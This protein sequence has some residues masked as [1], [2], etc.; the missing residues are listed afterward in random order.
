M[1]LDGAPT[2]RSGSAMTARIQVELSEDE[3]HAWLRVSPGAPVG[4]E[5]LRE[6]LAAAGVGHGIDADAVAELVRR[7]ADPEYS[8]ARIEIATGRAMQRASSGTCELAVPLGLQSGHRN[9]DGSFDYR[10]RG[11]LTV[12]ESGQVVGRCAPPVAGSEGRTVTGR[13][14]P[15]ERAPQSGPSFGEGLVRDA[16]GNVIAARTGVLRRG[17]D[18]AISIGD[19]YA[20][21]GDVDMHSGHLEMRGSL[22]VAGDVTAKF[23]VQ[24]T[25]DVDIGKSVARGTVY[26]GGSVRVHGGIF[27][28]AMAELDVEAEHGQGAVVHAGGTVHLRR[29]AV[30]C[31]LVACCVRVDGAVRGGRVLAEQRIVV[32]DA[33]ARMG[34]ETELAVAIEIPRPI[35]AL[36]EEQ[37]R[38]RHLADRLAAQVVHVR[39][40][41]HHTAVP[42]SPE[43]IAHA[44][45]VHALALAAS[46]D[47]LGTIHAG[48][49]VAIGAHRLLLEQ[50]QRH[51][52]FR[53]DEDTLAIRCDPLP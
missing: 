31:E 3:L 14:I 38:E 34:G 26:A 53:L 9:A 29:A 27:G 5:T 21:D 12:V 13:T 20:H 17:D 50:P 45:H 28:A 25:G 37:R 23:E 30:S 49:T 43:A 32:G 41:E 33:G 44:D 7:L 46:I 51:C 47:V 22:S 10:D 18:D 6:V 16:H 11:L 2:S 40:R 42:G 4:A 52:R 35:R 24:A 48:C 1:L 19:H 39:E 8:C 15:C 36:F